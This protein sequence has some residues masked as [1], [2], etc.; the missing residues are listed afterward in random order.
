MNI[1]LDASYSLGENLSGVGVYSRELMHGLLTEAP[2]V[3]WSW[4]YRPQHWRQVCCGASPPQVKRRFLWETRTPGGGCDLFHGLGQRLPAAFDKLPRRTRTIATFHDLFVLTANY[5][6]P[7]FRAR[8]TSQAR[9]AAERADAI[10][11][12]SSFTAGQ[13]EELLGVESRR[14][15]VV[16]HG[17]RPLPAAAGVARERMILSV[18]AL[19]VRKNTLALVR[20]FEQ[21]PPGWS[22]VLAGS[23]GYGYQETIK[24][25]IEASSRRADIVLTGWIDDTS[26]GRLYARAW[27]FAF[28]SLDEGFGIPVL[29]AMAA[30]VPVLASD[31]SAL[32]EVC[33]NAALLVDPHNVDAI[34]AGLRRLTED[35]LLRGE[36]I[37]RGRLRAA[38]FTWERCA[39]STWEVYRSLLG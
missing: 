9:Q 29:E 15:H 10:I 6:H 22:L 23:A 1:A 33:G 25:A 35:E 3:D 7:E 5:S 32:P 20:A 12:V 8:M 21:L 11:A 36:L 17:V 38:G 39:R 14:I 16:P 26:L 28:P 18:G 30:G 13:V 2:G 4:A 31:T 37:E 27:A 34:A 19:Q 24:P